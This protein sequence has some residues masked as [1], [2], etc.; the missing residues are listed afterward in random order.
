MKFDLR[1]PMVDYAGKQLPNG[2]DG[3]VVNMRDVIATA[4][5]TNNMPGQ[6]ETL[7]A[8]DKNKTYQILQK[9]WKRWKIELSHS[10]CEFIKMRA[11]KTLDPLLYGRLDDFLE[12]H[13]WDMPIPEEDQALE[14][15]DAEKKAKR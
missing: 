9:V 7:S 14:E 15:A 12:D 3:E 13:P 4:L 6:Q 1:K 8:E 11:G 5:Q 10:E 2:P